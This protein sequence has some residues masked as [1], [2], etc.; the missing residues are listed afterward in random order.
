MR[1]TRLFKITRGTTQAA[2]TMYNGNDPR[3]LERYSSAI[4]LSDME[5]F[6][7]PE[8]LY[9]LVLANIMSPRLW[10]WRSDPW[11]AG[12]EKMSLPRRVQRLKQ[13]VMDN[14][15]F[16][17]DLDTWGLTTKEREIARFSPFIDVSV[18]SRSNALFGYEGDKYYFDSDIRKHFGLDKYTSNVIPYWKTETLEAME[19]FRFKPGYP[20]GAGECV[21]LSALYAAALFVVAGIPLTD[22]YLLATPLHSQNYIDVNSGILTNNRR[23]LT[24]AMWFNGSELSA[25]A[26]RALENEQVTIVADCTGWIHFLYESATIDPKRY[27]RFL[28][29]LR[30]YLSTDIISFEILANFLRWR[31]QL[32]HCFQIAH[33]A[34]SCTRYIEAEKVFAYEHGSKARVSDS[35]R[36]QLLDEIEEDEFYTGPIEG[37]LVLNE[38]EEFFRTTRISL[39][40]GIAIEKLKSR[41]RHSCFSVDKVIAELTTFCRTEPRLP[42]ADGK[43]FSAVLPVALDG[44]TSA[45]EAME[46]I[47]RLREHNESCDLAFSA[48]RDL[49][50][51]PWKPFLKAAFERNPVSVNGLRDLSLDSACALIAGFPE[52]SIYHESTRL[53]QPDEVWNFRRGD[54][55]EKAI[56]LANLIKAREPGKE[57][58]FESKNGT[59][60]LFTEGKVFEFRT[61]KTVQG[62]FD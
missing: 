48:F 27:R 42:S 19:S 14:F 26:R 47:E 62:P 5:V 36:Q 18:L 57:A 8:L 33:T 35:T 29:A 17:L 1:E 22:I 55:L 4:T 54:G 52:E 34:F 6:I 28:P 24:K 51:S 53:A 40:D 44:V 25:K 60:R 2:G 58:R 20:T 23:I 7:F 37:R 21:S 10:R 16:N 61:A 9:A 39:D 38:L 41:L 12:I 31:S 15:S 32:Q 56:C 45:V 59:M 3:S 13:Y 30:A 46:R 49:S 43:K 50:R 11:F